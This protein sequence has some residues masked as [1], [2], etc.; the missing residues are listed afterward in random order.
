MIFIFTCHDVFHHNFFSD[1]KEESL[2]ISSGPGIRVAIAYWLR[3]SVIILM[4]KYESV[5]SLALAW[6]AR[7]VRVGENETIVRN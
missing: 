7:A 3:L 2:A 4:L 1:A 5:Y 6:L